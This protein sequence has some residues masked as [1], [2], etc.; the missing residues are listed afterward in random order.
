MPGPRFTDWTHVHVVGD[1]D[2]AAPYL[3]FARKLLGFVDA[4][5]RRGGLGTHIARRRLEDGAEV[6]A[7]VRGGIP[8]ITI[9][10]PPVPSAQQEPPML[11]DFVVF[12]RNDALPDGIDVEHPE[13]VLRL[14]KGDT[15]RT[16]TFNDE[17]MQGRSDGTYSGAFPNGV[18]HA[19]NCDWIGPRDVRLS[20]YG[21]SLR[22]WCDRWRQPSAIYGRWVFMLGE[23]LLDIDAYC[24]DAAIAMAE[25]L[26]LGA[27]V[28]GPWLYV[29]Q[30]AM[31]D[32]PDPPTAPVGRPLDVFVT[33]PF[34]TGQVTLRL[35]RYRIET[36]DGEGGVLRYRV[37][38]GSHEALWS[39]V[40]FCTVNPWF[41]SPEGDRCSSVVMPPNVHLRRYSDAS[42]AYHY[43]LPDETH[44]IAELTIGDDGAVTT[45]VTT[46]GLTLHDSSGQAQECVVAVDYDRDG[47]RIELLLGYVAFA[48]PLDYLAGIPG[49]PYQDPREDFRF[50]LPWANYYFRVGEHRIPLFQ[51]SGTNSYDDAWSRPLTIDIRE[52]AFV[53]GR[54]RRLPS[55][56]FD[57][58]VDLHV[59]NRGVL[60]GSVELE[61]FHEPNI[62]P[63]LH[64]HWQS[65]I[66]EGGR[67]RATPL[68][69]LFGVAMT[70]TS[71]SPYPTGGAWSPW[72]QYT[73]VGFNPPWAFQDPDQLFGV[74]VFYDDTG[75]AADSFVTFAEQVPPDAPYSRY[76]DALGRKQA[77]A[78]A[79]RDGVL[80]FSG[81][82][83]Q[84]GDGARNVHYATKAHLPALTGVADAGARFHPLWLIGRPPQPLV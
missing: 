40:A 58:A 67:Q 23:T 10:P 20:W 59:Y 66:T 34:T 48:A 28:R 77:M 5:A 13:Q 69:L 18:R 17:V 37:L 49:S 54:Y 41:F 83:H 39:N 44:Q 82:G 19:G 32:M 25:R 45:E 4:E 65:L 55:D 14:R 7:E 80:L 12:A 9:I 47:N 43:N 33:T 8:R 29:M 57:I 68:S 75:T 50:V 81:P 46:D 52:G 71:V 38:V 62:R 11:G 27:A 79:S 26:V 73:D 74:S 60:D 42:E 51:A 72:A 1:R 30:A 70:G 63:P 21:P 2:R 35:M 31:P 53:F 3:P 16:Y 36:T 24:A 22:Y 84:I 15:W 76:P 56:P 61:R 78:M 64:T 6:I